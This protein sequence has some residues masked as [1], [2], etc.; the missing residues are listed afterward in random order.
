MEVGLVRLSQNGYSDSMLWGVS[1]M[2]TSLVIIEVYY[3]H[4]PTLVPWCDCYDHTASLCSTQQSS[5]WNHVPPIR[6]SLGYSFD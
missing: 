6:P 5:W 4:P 3:T 1:R 2:R